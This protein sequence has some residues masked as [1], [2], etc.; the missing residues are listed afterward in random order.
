MLVSHVRTELNHSIDVPH[1]TMYVVS[2][3]LIG[4]TTMLVSH[5]RTEL[6]H[7]IDVP[8]LTMY[9]VSAMLIGGF[10]TNMRH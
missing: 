10:C 6:N 8:H 9:V 1:L 7:S 5:V 4:G 2:T 3:M